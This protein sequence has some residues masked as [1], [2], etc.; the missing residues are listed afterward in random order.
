MY[1]KSPAKDAILFGK[2][3]ISNQ[4]ARFAPKLYVDLTHQTGRGNEEEEALQIAN[5]FIDCFAEYQKHLDLNA[6]RISSF[7]KGKLV[8]EYGPGD[9]LGI[10]LLFYAHGA[11]AV[12][13]VDRFPLS[14]LS[15]K[16]IQVYR[17]LLNSLAADKRDRAENAFNE[18]GN[19]ESG[20]NTSVINYKITENG[21][22]DVRNTYD[23]IISRA[24]LEHV[25]VLDKTM[26]DI[27][28]GLKPEGISLHQVDLKSHGLDRY[29]DFDFLTWPSILYKLM[30]SHKG[31]P[32]RLRVNK[33]RELAEQAQLKVKHL[34]PTGQLD[35]QKVA[36]IY[37]K[38][39]KEFRETTPEELSW[40][41][42]WIYLEN[43]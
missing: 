30:Y 6:E 4:L 38:V 10:A 27:K 29:T 36:L 19:P 35:S 15:A 14:K 16:N 26:L 7:L 42:F 2:A 21:L 24:V 17:H 11:E 5:Y 13:C 37:A 25:N 8:L 33:Y 9:I 3:C 41:G 40:L 1:T 43:A 28:Q 22:A 18:K 39:A 34:S 20:F 23:L 12:H 32:N 31:F